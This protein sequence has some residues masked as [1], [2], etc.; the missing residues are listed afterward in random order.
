MNYR[1]LDKLS[2][3]YFAAII[4][5]GII[6]LLTIG[7]ILTRTT[8]GIIMLLVY[9]QDSYKFGYPLSNLSSYN[10]LISSSV[11]WAL[12]IYFTGKVLVAIISTVKIILNTRRFISKLEIISSKNNKYIFKSSG[13]EVFTAGILNSRIYI[14]DSLKI[15]HSK[16]EIRAILTH[17]QR[18]VL[19]RDPLRTTLVSMITKALPNLPLK[20][21]LI[22]N[23][24]VLT[25]ICADRLAQEKMLDSLPVVSAL[26]KRLKMTEPRI[27]ASINFFSAQ[28]ERISILVGKQ[29]LSRRNMTWL[30]SF[31]LFA[32][33]LGSYSILKTNFYTCPHLTNCITSVSSVLNFH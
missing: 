23:F 12:G 20:D 1:S 27:S 24:N 25:E 8:P 21:K 10:Q 7:L 16:K 28:S 22:R 31:T 6:Y 29:I 11:L 26:Y 14:A 18:H 4:A 13:G 9:L 19:A 2:N 3:F 15:I 30:A 33:M 17:E 5:I 32:L